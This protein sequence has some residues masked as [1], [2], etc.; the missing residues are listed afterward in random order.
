MKTN[1]V[2]WKNCDVYAP[3]HMGLRDILISAGKIC[4]IEPELSIWER[5]EDVETLDAG[6][7]PVC[8][9]IVD[10][11]IHVTGGGGE[12]GPASR[13]PEIRLSELVTNG[14][15]TVLGMLG[16]DGI[17]RSLENLLFKCRALEEEGVSTYML[18]GSYRYP[19]P[20]LTG[21]VMRDISLIDKIVGVKLAVSD[22]RSSGVTGEELIRIASEARIGGMLG[23]KSG[24][25]VLHMG[26]SEK[27]FAPVFYALEHSDILAGNFLPTHC[28]RNPE[29]VAEAV[30]FNQLGGAIDFTADT[31]T[32]ENIPGAA[33]VLCS[34]L[35]Q[36]ADPLR[37]TVS[38]DACGSQPVFDS[39]GVCVGLTY[40]SPAT[41]LRELRRL[42]ERQGLP[43]STALRFFTEN[44][45]RVL[46]LSGVKGAVVPGA[47]ADL[48]ALS[49]D[50]RP[51]HVLAR[52]KTAVRDGMAVM[53]GRFE[54]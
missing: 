35:K 10:L 23:G 28:G 44:P 45:A 27:R 51:L 29:L 14:V 48:L 12:Q 54:A 30:R 53:K 25:A 32:G 43:L 38:S 1:F 37:V 15:T 42:V 11:H 26:A 34:A 18:T 17:S 8:P 13:V 46:G 9:G 52:G 3:E 7:A 50:F 4:L 6:G 21:S 40:T 47:D 20:T 39:N 36:G 41:L 31:D 5:R 2:L 49:S 19:S 22:H 24:L 33:A 16:T